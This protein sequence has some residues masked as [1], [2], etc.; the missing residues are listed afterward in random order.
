MSKNLNCKKSWH[1]SRFEQQSKIQKYIKEKEER[2]KR[3]QLI[4]FELEREKN[5]YKTIKRMNWMFENY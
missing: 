2:E 1:P 4:L 3:K 5:N